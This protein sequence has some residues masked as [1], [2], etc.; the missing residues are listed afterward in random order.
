MNKDQETLRQE[1]KTS[2]ELLM[3]IRNLLTKKQD[4]QHHGFLSNHD[5]DHLLKDSLKKT[6]QMLKK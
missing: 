4:E 2:E 5:I 6:E 1:Q 3:E